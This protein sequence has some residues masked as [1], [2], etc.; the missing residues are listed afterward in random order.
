MS[1]S[2]KNNEDMIAYFHT[3]FFSEYAKKEKEHADHLEAILQAHGDLVKH[4]DFLMVASNHRW[5]AAKIFAD[6]HKI[7]KSKEVL[8]VFTEAKKS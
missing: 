2:V 3:F 5:D 8:G 6:N 7:G 4:M 1:K